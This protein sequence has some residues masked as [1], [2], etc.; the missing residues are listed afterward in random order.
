MSQ[1]GET[2]LHV[3][4]AYSSPSTVSWLLERGAK[5]NVQDVNGYTPLTW[6]CLKQRVES[7]RLLLAA[8]ADVNIVGK[9]TGPLHAAAHLR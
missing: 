2:L 3:A 9:F 8:G 4:A 5:V 6:A 7:V 1:C